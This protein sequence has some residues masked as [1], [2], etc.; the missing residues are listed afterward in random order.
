MQDASSKLRN[1]DFYVKMVFIAL[2][3]ISLRMIQKRVFRDSTFD[4][5]FLTTNIKVLAGLSL[6]FWL[7]ALTAGRLMAY[8]GPVSG[9][10]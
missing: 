2:A 6:F 7:G 10:G 3:L 5:S 9:L 8:V 4:Q 1:P